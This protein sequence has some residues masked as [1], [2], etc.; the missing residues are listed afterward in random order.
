MSDSKAPISGARQL[1]LKDVQLQ[2]TKLSKPVEFRG[3]KQWE[4]SL[5]TDDV[6]VAQDWAFNHL[7][8]K[9]VPAMAP[10]S[11]TVSLNRK[12]HTKD[13]T[14]QEPVRVVDASKRAI[15][16]EARRHGRRD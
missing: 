14:E 9:G 13:G 8:V 5:I 4:T 3:N 11:W 1:M 7:N 15:S 2:Y 16:D 10:T 6:K 12:T